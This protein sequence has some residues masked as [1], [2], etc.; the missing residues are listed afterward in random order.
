M[1]ACCDCTMPDLGE[2]FQPSPAGR[3]GDAGAGREIG[4]GDCRVG[5]QV[6]QD[7]PVGV[8]EHGYLTK[9]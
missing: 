7:A 5:K 3:R 6:T 4:G 1:T 8:V 2:F 9:G